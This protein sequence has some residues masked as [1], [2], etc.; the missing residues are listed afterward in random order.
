MSA[1]SNWM[2]GPPADAAVAI[3]P[4]SI[5]VA[6]LGAQGANVHVQGYAIE[7][8][9]PG[10]LV[11]SLTATNVVDAG[12]VAAALRSAVERLGGRPRRV[13]LIVPDP[14]ARVSLVRFDRVPARHEDLE[15]LIRWQVRKSAPFPVE[16]AALTFAPGAATDDGGREFVAVLARRNIVREYEG[17]CEAQ[18]MH[19]GLVDLS[20]F[21]VVN[22]LLASDPVPG[23]D[24]L[25]VHVRPEYTSIAILR[26]DEM[27]FFRS[28]SEADAEALVNVVHQTTMYYQDRLAGRGFR[29][30]R[31]GGLGGNA[32]ALDTI[33]RSLEERL[34]VQVQPIDPTR[35]AA[36]PGRIAASGE[37]LATL[38]PLVGTLMRMRAEVVRA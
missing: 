4:E 25:V 29:E 23:G 22:L 10:A 11:A 33:R 31:L 16:D 1:F 13:A 27:I 18:G 24:R 7:P 35:T 21:S 6:V 5:A 30:V 19:A 34:A 38:A 36:L 2:A 9:P 14:I 8:L 37:L 32:A 20:T 17:V 15:Q 28:L 3:A 26:R 12:A